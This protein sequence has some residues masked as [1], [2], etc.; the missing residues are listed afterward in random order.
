MTPRPP[1]AP[2][3]LVFWTACAAFQGDASSRSD[4]DDGD[5]AFGAPGSSADTGSVG[6]GEAFDPDARWGLSGTL[7]LTDDVPDPSRSLLVLSERGPVSCDGAVFLQAAQDFPPPPSLADVT[8]W[9]RLTLA[10]TPPA[11][12][13]TDD[14]D[15]STDSDIGDTDPTACVPRRPRQVF[16]GLGPPRPEQ[17]PAADRAGVPFEGS[18]GLYLGVEESRGVLAGLATRT[19]GPVLVDTDLPDSDEEDSDDPPHDTADT[20]QPPAQ[21]GSWELT[22]LH[23]TPYR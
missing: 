19:E 15:P 1:P 14:S 2:L 17:R 16:V 8:R 5:A 20:G 9:W 21:D 18:L 22:I 3:F 7:V 23:A 4:T 12:P 6:D 11:S 13:S 10:D